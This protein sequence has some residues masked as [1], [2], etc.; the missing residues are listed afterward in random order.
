MEEVEDTREKVGWEEEVLVPPPII[1]PPPPPPPQPLHVPVTVTVGL[2]V[3]PDRVAVC[4][5]VGVMMG[6]RVC[7]RE[8]V[9]VEH[10]VE[11]WVPRSWVDEGVREPP[12]GVGVGEK[13][14]EGEGV[15]VDKGA[16]GVKGEEGEGLCV[17]QEEGVGLRGVP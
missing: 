1:P 15:S 3:I 9:E 17:G 13:V 16:V 4:V 14:L 12:P 7:R 6:V 10:L 11:E 2:E 5:T 8:G